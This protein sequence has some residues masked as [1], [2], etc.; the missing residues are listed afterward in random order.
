[1]EKLQLLVGK[2][3]LPEPS[4]LSPR[5]RWVREAIII[6]YLHESVQFIW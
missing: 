3:L 2:L 4:F 1:M 5:R 6:R